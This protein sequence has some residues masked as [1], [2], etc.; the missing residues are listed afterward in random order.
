MAITNTI[1]AN[2][3][4]YIRAYAKFIVNKNES[5]VR[6]QL[7]KHTSSI[8]AD[9][10][11]HGQTGYSNGVFLLSTYDNTR[12]TAASGSLPLLGR[13]Y[14]FSLKSLIELIASVEEVLTVSSAYSEYLLL[15][16]FD[17]KSLEQDWRKWG[18]Y[19][20]I[21]IYNSELATY[22]NSENW[23]KVNF[24]T[25]HDSQKDLERRYLNT[26]T[27]ECH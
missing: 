11:I 18:K 20:H 12:I 13:R 14:Y 6:A 15:K 26:N 9:L 21:H 2:G 4:K 7:N 25:I 23:V 17:S 3:D 27:K 10:K 5:Y 1:Y 24:P 19:G 22:Y 16:S 8:P